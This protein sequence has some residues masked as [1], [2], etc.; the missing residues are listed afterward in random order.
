MPNQVTNIGGVTSAITTTLAYS[1]GT[2]NIGTIPANSQIISVHIDVTTAFNAGT[3]NNITVGY[4]GSNAAYVTATSGASAGRLNVATTG[5]YSAWANTG[6]SDLVATV[7]YAQSGTA[8]S[9]GAA[10][11]TIVYKSYAP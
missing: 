9:A 7:T 10:Q 2:V 11:V 5:V 6:S 3:N 1:N 4:A 8:A